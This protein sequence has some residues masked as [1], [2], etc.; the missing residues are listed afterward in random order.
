MI[1]E[2][3][4][5]Q[6]LFVIINGSALK[7]NIF[8]FSDLLIDMLSESDINVKLFGLLQHKAGQ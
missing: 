7:I 2:H 8:D 1:N 5:L 3:S 4:Y 6:L